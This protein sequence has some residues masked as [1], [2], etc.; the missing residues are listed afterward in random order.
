MFPRTC[1]TRLEARLVPGGGQRGSR[2]LQLTPEIKMGDRG[3]CQSTRAPGL[4]TGPGESRDTAFS[5]CSDEHLLGAHGWELQA[6]LVKVCGLVL[7]KDGYP[8]G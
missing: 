3:H 5:H 1:C 8:D 7:G 2:P 4:H 6:G